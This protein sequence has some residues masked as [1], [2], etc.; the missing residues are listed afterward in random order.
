VKPL[1]ADIT[2]PMS[3]A[4]GTAEVDLDRRDSRL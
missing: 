2:A 1:K 3:E 4:G